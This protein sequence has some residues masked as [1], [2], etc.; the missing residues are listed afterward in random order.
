MKR[1]RRRTMDMVMMVINGE[2]EIAVTT[3]TKNIS[4]IVVAVVVKE[5]SLIVALRV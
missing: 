5:K 4:F 3:M 2:R 1:T